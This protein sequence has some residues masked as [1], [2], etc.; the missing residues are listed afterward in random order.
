MVT[1]MSSRGR[2]GTVIVLMIVVAVCNCRQYDD[3]VAEGRPVPLDQLLDAH[4]TALASASRRQRAADD[5]RNWRKNRVRVWGKRTALDDDD[6]DNYEG[7]TL[8][9]FLRDKSRRR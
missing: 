2:R 5:K 6:D 1:M 4:T 3:I 8:T 9:F 7:L